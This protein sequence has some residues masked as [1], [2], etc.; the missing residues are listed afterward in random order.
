MENRL[1]TYFRTGFTHDISV[2][3]TYP[4]ENG[5]GYEKYL[6]GVAPIEMETWQNDQEHNDLILFVLSIYSKE[7]DNVMEL[8]TAECKTNLETGRIVGAGFVG[9]DIYRF[10]LAVN[11]HTLPAFLTPQEIWEGVVH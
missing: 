10:N 6:L 7:M 8:V 3:G 5:C 11:D 1:K 4:A 2:F 9:Y